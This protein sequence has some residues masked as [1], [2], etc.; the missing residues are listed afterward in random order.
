MLDKKISMFDH[1]D[2]LLNS[3]LSL[4]KNEQDEY[5][6]QGTGV[7]ICPP[8]IAFFLLLPTLLNLCLQRY[9]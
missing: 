3:I 4:S 8:E 1:T 2:T 9:F 5:Y 7:K 6:Y